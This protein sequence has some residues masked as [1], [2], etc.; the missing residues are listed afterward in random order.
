[1][2][3]ESLPGIGT[4]DTRGRRLNELRL[5]IV[6]RCNY[7]CPYCMPA[8]QIDEKRDFLS[9]SQRMS[10]DE[11]ELLVRAFVRVGI[12]KLRLTGGEPLLR[13]DLPTLIR[14]LAAIEQLEDLA[15]TTNGSL[16]T[17][18]AG[19]LREAGLHRLTVS[20]DSLDPRQF[21]ALS[22]G[23]GRLDEVLAGVD[24][25]VDAGFASLR[26]NCVI[27]RGVNEDQIL[28]LSEHFRGTPHV[29]RFIEY[30][31]VGTLND[32]TPQA[33][34]SAAEVRERIAQHYPMIPLSGG[35]DGTTASRYAYT[36]GQGEIGFVA[37]VSEP[38][39]SDCGRARVA[40]NGE[41]YTCL[42]ASS[43]VDLLTPMRGGA[44]EQALAQR[45]AAIWSGRQDRYSE[46]RGAAQ[47][48]ALPVRVQ[49]YTVGG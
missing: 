13:K 35:V 44:D 31:D 3:T 11:I 19:A 23:R 4:L 17:A 45:I 5:S 36:D 43:G 49:M 32:W 34:V 7:R 6:D 20:M 48:R 30:M 8:D 38:F 40:A 18:Q 25:A 2:A 33:V 46:L 42:F 9:P 1:M 28:P 39:C 26:I 41:M 29:L 22:G 15:L 24:A 21:A 16:L 47:A 37:S 12:T 27:Q 10:A 14:R